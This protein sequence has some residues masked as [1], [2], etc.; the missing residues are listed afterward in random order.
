MSEKHNEL[1]LNKM[2][3]LFI[4]SEFAEQEMLKQTGDNKDKLKYFYVRPLYSIKLLQ[5]FN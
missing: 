1:K 4:C 2:Q 5:T 3:Y